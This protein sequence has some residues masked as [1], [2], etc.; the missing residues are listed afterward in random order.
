MNCQACMSDNVDIHHIHCTECLGDLYLCLVCILNTKE[1]TLLI[2]DR[3]VP[4]YHA[5]HPECRPPPANAVVVGP[6][7]L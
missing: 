2:N 7:T 3:L 6:R 5:V 1:D 4:I